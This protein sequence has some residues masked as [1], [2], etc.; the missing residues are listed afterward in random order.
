MPRDETNSPSAPIASAILG[1][2]LRLDEQRD[3]GGDVR[4]IFGQ[5]ARDLREQLKVDA[6]V[7][8]E[9]NEAGK[10]AADAALKEIAEASGLTPDEAQ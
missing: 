1:W 8:P 4:N 10:Q 2:R 9:R 5:A 3:A 7:H 6:T